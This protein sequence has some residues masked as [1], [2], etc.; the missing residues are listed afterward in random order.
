M[1]QKAATST[2]ATQ[3]TE[4]ELPDGLLLGALS[5]SRGDRNDRA[6]FTSDNQLHS[7]PHP[8]ALTADDPHEIGTPVPP[9]HGFSQVGGARRILETRLEDQRPRTIAAAGAAK[10]GTA[11]QSL[12]RMIF[13]SWVT[14][15]VGLPRSPARTG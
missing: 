4:P 15:T 7:N 9:T 1:D 14:M 12:A 10:R 3:Q 6:V 5:V 8:P 13:C 11:S 2:A